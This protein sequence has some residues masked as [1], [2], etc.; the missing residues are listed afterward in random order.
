MREAWH[1]PSF[2]TDSRSKQA[3]RTRRGLSILKLLVGLA[4]AGVF[5]ASIAPVR[6]MV[7]FQKLKNNARTYAEVIENIL[8]AYQTQ[9]GIFPLEVSAVGQDYYE[10]TT[11]AAL[12]AILLG[13]NKKANPLGVDFDF[14]NIGFSEDGCRLEGPTGNQR[15]LD[16]WGN[17]FHVRLDSDEDGYTGEVEGCAKVRNRNDPD[18]TRV[19]H[20]VIV[21]S[22]SRPKAD[23]AF[24]NC[25]MWIKSWE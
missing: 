13:T 25:S 20:S 8:K 9:Y 16:P 6:A 22:K 12:M 18:P 24:E 7:R 23:G 2:S 19:R 4:V 17:E 11:N 3:S 5:V 15:L 10:T 21:W 1:V 14:F